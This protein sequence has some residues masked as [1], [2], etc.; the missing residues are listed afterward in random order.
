MLLWILVWLST[1]TLLPKEEREVFVSLD[2]GAAESLNNLLGDLGE[3][4]PLS[5]TTLFG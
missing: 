5:S 2:I 3:T 4:L 1:C